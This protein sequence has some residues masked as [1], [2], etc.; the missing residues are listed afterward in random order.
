MSFVAVPSLEKWE[1]FYNK[2]KHYHDYVKKIASLLIPEQ[3]SVLEF[4]SKRGELLTSLNNKI[5]VGVEYSDEFV[6]AAKKLHTK[7][8]IYNGT[9]PLKTNKSF[10]Y[11]IL[12]HVVSHTTDVQKFIETLKPFT[13][14][15]TRILVFFFNYL[16]KPILDIAVRIDLKIPD[17]IHPN[18]LSTTDVDNLFYLESYEKLKSNTRFLFPIKV[19][20]VSNFINQFV[21]PLP[22]FNKLGIINYSLYRPFPK[23]HDYSVSIV[24][25][26]RNE[27][28][29]MKR[30]LDKIPLLGKKTEVIFVEGHSKDNTYDAIKDEIKRYKGKITASL[31]RQIGIGKADAVRLGFSKASNDLLMI[32][33]ADLTVDPSDLPKFY[34]AAASGKADFV[35]GSRL[36]YPMEKLAMRF[37]N[38]IGNKV[39]SVLFSFL[40]EQNIRD[41]LCGTKVLLQTNYQKIVKN[42]HI[43]GD[44]DPFG[45][46][47]LI[48]GAAKLNHRILEIPIRYKERTYGT[49]NIS[50]FKHGM[51]LFKMVGF[52]ARKI[53]FV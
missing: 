32:L 23:A 3:A 46:Y 28:G 19:P 1:Y 49:T 34:D 10:D 4:G 9:Q 5:K 17:S 12:T 35:M 47:D 29:N 20:V 52:A 26:A 22:V 48:F 37:L 40:L 45:D 30:V 36:V 25:P 24:I 44:F 43:F 21:A 39:F 41:T 6:K 7:L 15:N 11:I 53:K 2:N 42:R 27:S 14:E 33:D 18:W 8:E 13:H 50:R 51:L 31:Y 38:Q 16:W